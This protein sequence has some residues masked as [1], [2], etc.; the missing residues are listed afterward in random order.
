VTIVDI[1][2]KLQKWSIEDSEGV[3]ADVLIALDTLL[4]FNRNMVDSA[5]EKLGQP[6]K[7]II[8]P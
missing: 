2:N 7:D 1:I 4:A 6:K 3:P 8:I 5:R